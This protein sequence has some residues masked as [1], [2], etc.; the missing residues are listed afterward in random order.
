MQ[1]ANPLNRLNKPASDI[2]ADAS[3]MLKKIATAMFRLLFFTY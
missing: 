2:R 1:Q 3:T